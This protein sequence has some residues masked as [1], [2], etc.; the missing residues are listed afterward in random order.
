ML[1]TSCSTWSQRSFRCWYWS[2]VTLYSETSLS[3]KKSRFEQRED[4]KWSEK[5]S[6][7]CST[8]LFGTNILSH[9]TVC[10]FY[11]CNCL[12]KP[13]LLRVP[14][15]IDYQCKY[16]EKN[17]ETASAGGSNG[18]V[19][20][21]IEKWHTHTTTVQAPRGDQTTHVIDQCTTPNLFKADCL[22]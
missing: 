21:W 6:L 9:C 11:T 8:Q 13:A 1:Q 10:M 2:E 18:C 15:K 14:N 17:R 7:G 12:K 4:C 3:C 5:F 19:A 16:R 20:Y 22:Q